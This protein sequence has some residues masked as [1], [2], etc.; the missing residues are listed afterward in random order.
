MDLTVAGMSLGNVDSSTITVLV[1]L[2]GPLVVGAI[3]GLKTPSWV[4]GV[5]ATVISASV[6]TIQVYLDG[7]WARDFVNQFLQTIVLWQASYAMLWKSTG[8]AGWLQD[9]IP[10]RLGE[11]REDLAIQKKVAA[12]VEVEKAVVDTPKAPH[13]PTVVEAAPVVVVEPA[14]VVVEPVEIIDPTIEVVDNEEELADMVDDD[15]PAQTYNGPQEDDPIQDVSQDPNI[16]LTEGPEID[17][18]E[19]PEVTE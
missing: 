4:K 8:I 11:Q 2:M 9:L 5:L 15:V 16:D 7:G 17:E 12:H 1:G 19:D 13:V 10:I 18:E 6:A 14:P 3:T